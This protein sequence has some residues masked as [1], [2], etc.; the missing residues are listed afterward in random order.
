MVAA[1]DVAD[2]DE[3]TTD[4]IGKS[5]AEHLSMDRASVNVTVS[6]ASVRIQIQVFTGN[7]SQSAAVRERLIGVLGSADQATAFFA[8]AGVANV[9]IASAPQFEVRVPLSLPP[10][11]PGSSGQSTPSLPAVS[12]EA[13]VPISAQRAEDDMPAFGNAVLPIVTIVVLVL[14]AT[15]LLIGWYFCS[16]RGSKQASAKAQKA[17]VNVYDVQIQSIKVAQRS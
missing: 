1:G 14:F 7:E 12:G 8:S 15:G 10:A 4:A 11:T 6:P 13:A 5:V 2:F 9:S 3:T 17:E 16:R